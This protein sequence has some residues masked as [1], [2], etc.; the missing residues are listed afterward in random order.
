MGYFAQAHGTLNGDHTVLDELMRHKALSPGEARGLL[1]RYLFR[2]DAVFKPVSALSG[3]ERAKLAL[4]VLAL[5]GAGVLI[6]DEPTNH[7]DIPAQE[8]LQEVLE[9][10]DGTILMVTHDRYLVDRLATQIWSIDDGQMRV[11]SGTYREFLTTERGVKSDD[12]SRSQSRPLR[13]LA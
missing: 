11:F 3:G 12:E 10:F 8:A 4:A 6:L 1:A 2:E 9:T 7:L 5:E 13:A